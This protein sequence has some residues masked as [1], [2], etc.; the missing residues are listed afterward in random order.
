MNTPIISGMLFVAITVLAGLLLSATHTGFALYQRRFSEQLQNQLNGLFMFNDAARLSSAYLIALVLMPLLLWLAG[1]APL[2]VVG[3]FIAQLSAPRILFS[4]LRARRATAI[5]SALPDALSQLA[6]AMRAGATF[7]VALQGLVEEDAGP[8]GEELSLLLREHRM[9]ARMEDALD[10]LAERVRS[11]EMD[12]VV[13]AVLIA[14]DV[15]GSLA[16]ILQGLSVTIRRKL[17]MEGK[18]SALTSQGMLQGYV[19]SAL[20]FGLLAALSFIEPEATLP[21]FNSVLGWCVLS[22]M[23]ILQLFG[24]LMI[25]KIVSIEI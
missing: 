2:L 24:A 5:N 6:S 21:I 4:V 8:L 14:Q 11:E 7:T 22:V 23:A 16:E 12:L 20:P 3:L 15:G 9:G 10:N 25:R 19:V 17:D 18:I 1:F 13:S